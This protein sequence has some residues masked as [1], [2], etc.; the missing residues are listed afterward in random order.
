MM[1]LRSILL[2]A[3]TAIT[4]TIPGQ[5][6][7]ETPGNDM[8]ERGK[9]LVVVTGCNDC[10]T[11]GYLLSQGDV[12]EEEWLTGNPVGWRG[13]WGTT[14][15]ANLRTLVD[16]LTSEQWVVPTKTL[17]ARPPMPWFNLNALNEQDSLAMYEYIRHLGP[18][19][20]PA[21]AYVPPDQSP[22]TPYSDLTVRSD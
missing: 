18:A 5:L 6:M 2:A 21:P 4:I 15:G 3:I 22:K 9:Y 7:A 16:S 1:R 8:V 12:P 19:G 11:A 13:P 10:H 20:A 14:Y 17:K